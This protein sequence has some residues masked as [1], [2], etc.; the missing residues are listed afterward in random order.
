MRSFTNRML[1]GL[2][3]PAGQAG[4]ALR[5]LWP[6]LVA[7]L[8]L[9]LIAGQ[10][11]YAWR[12]GEGHLDENRLNL[13]A[14]HFLYLLLVVLLGLASLAALSLVMRRATASTFVRCFRN[15]VIASA[16]L[17]LLLPYVFAFGFM[18]RAGGLALA[19]AAIIASVALQ[20]ILGWREARTNDARG[21]YLVFL[22]V[23]ALTAAAFA[24]RLHNYFAMQRYAGPDDS[25]LGLMARHIMYKGARPV[26]FYGQAYNSAIDAYV[27]TLPFY[28][29]GPTAFALKLSAMLPM[30][31]AVPVIYLVGKE[32]YDVRTGLIAAVLTSLAP[33]YMVV[34]ANTQL[35]GYAWVFLLSALSLLLLLRMDDESFMERHPLLPWALLGFLSGLMFYIQPVSIPVIGAI[36]VFVM[37]RHYRIPLLP[38]LAFFALGCLPLIVYNLGHKFATLDELRMRTA[39]GLS[40][41][42]ILGNSRTEL[43]VS[44][45]VLTG[46]RRINTLAYVSSPW[47]WAP[48][49]LLYLGSFAYLAGRLANLS[50]KW[51][52]TSA[53]PELRRQRDGIF[54]V[55]LTGGLVLLNY[56][57]SSYVREQP[58]YPQHIIV[59]YIP[60]VLALGYSIS[61]ACDLI[62]GRVP[63]RLSRVARAALVLLPL[64][65]LLA[66]NLTS[67]GQMENQ[68]DCYFYNQRDF[69][70][71]IAW[72]EDRGIRHVYS[73]YT[74]GY[75][76]AFESK[77]R[78]VATPL[79]GP[80]KFD[81]YPPYSAEVDAAGEVAVVFCP[82]YTDSIAAMESALESRGIGYRREEFSLY[83]IFWDFSERPDIYSF[84]LPD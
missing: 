10:F 84:G 79:A 39:A 45:P 19:V 47:L 31:A 55:L 32:F 29:L 78:I 48:V 25:V 69:S 52:E 59:A 22:A 81:R 1:E 66:V 18:E 65:L 77:E 12:S 28:L 7:S 17:A 5:A 6:Y 56:A 9:L 41:S 36:L 21:S 70:D 13:P 3:S 37:V 76:L 40:L 2:R 11:L 53:L 14:Y 82:T 44:L 20:L 72:L 38:F 16:P 8:A 64:A 51:E 34:M 75:K 63:A 67:L 30:L 26:F 74:Y 62:A 24:L 42:S 73:G 43:A 54:L 46:I 23:F 57:M 50:R 27:M 60:L 49:L 33:A 58:R 71:L 4:R 83:V 61:R 15:A 80:V 35:G 68:E